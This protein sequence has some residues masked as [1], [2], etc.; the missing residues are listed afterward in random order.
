MFNA[1]FKLDPDS[2]DEKFDLGDMLENDNGSP[3]RDESSVPPA[4][5][6][7]AIAPAVE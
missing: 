3:L 1:N 5:D 4:I 6:Q 2:E 7:S